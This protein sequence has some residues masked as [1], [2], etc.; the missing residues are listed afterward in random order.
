MIILLTDFGLKDA[1]VGVMKGV[2][3]RF[4][5]NISIIDLCHFVTPQNII[6]AQT[7]LQDNYRFFPDDSIFCCVV[8]PEVGS[9]RQAIVVEYD[10]YCFVGPDNGLFTFA[11]LDNEARVYLLPV[12][13]NCSTTFHGRDLF[14]PFAAELECDRRIL[15]KLNPSH[16]YSCK[17]LEIPVPEKI[18]ETEIVGQVL[19]TDHFG[20]LITNIKYEQLPSLDLELNFQWT[21]LSLYRNY[22]DLPENGTGV[23]VGSSGRLEIVKKNGSAESFFRPYNKEVALRWK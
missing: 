17:V 23:L 21:K 4:N 1:Y 12:K 2:I 8:D 3:K 11:L 6:H 13:D 16:N 9:S 18:S 7:L 5:E 19:Y 15:K 22:L 14:A 20:N 10:G